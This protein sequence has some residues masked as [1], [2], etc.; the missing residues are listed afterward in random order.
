MS[1]LAKE[2]EVKGLR[3]KNRVVLPPL[4]TERST[5][6]GLATPQL[7]EHYRNLAGQE[8]AMIIIE[9][10]FVM[11]QG[12]ASAKQLGVDRDETVEGLSQLAQAIKDQ[13]CLGVMQINHAGSAAKTEVTGA[14]IVGPTAI[15]HPKNSEVV[16]RELTGNEIVAIVDAFAAAARRVKAAGFAGVEIHGA[17]GYLL[18]QFFSPLT[19]QRTDS[20]G[21]SRE[22]RMSFPMSIAEAVRDAIGPEML[23]MYRLG[24][25]DL[26][27]HGLTLEDAMALAPRLQSIGIDI[28][29]ISGGIGGSRPT[30][31]QG[32]QAYFAHLSE[33]IKQVVSE[34]VLVTGGITKAE[35]AEEL[36]RQERADLI[37]VGREL[38]KNPR[39][40]IEALET[41][42]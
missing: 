4:A 1:L 26:L 30:D 9:H 14:E 36:L 2:L 34:P 10:A 27:A 15:A 17:H 12:K 24:S 39:W 3:F 22:R 29:D 33:G 18:N 5:P 32:E 37:G 23:L 16:P 21:G 11:Q 41:L 38:L 7:I 31:L 8:L 40:A 13:G 35:V 42:D 6:D 19:N 25:D 28:F 20:Y